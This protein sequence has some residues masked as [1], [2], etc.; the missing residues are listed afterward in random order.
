MG[1][2]VFATRR[3][4][5]LSKDME[6]GVFV[7]AGISYV[8]RP[9]IIQRSVLNRRW[10]MSELDARFVRTS[11]FLWIVGAGGVVLLWVGIRRLIMLGV[12]RA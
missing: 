3:E 2:A 8:V 1:Y 9:S 5:H 6:F 4:Q 11:W 7:A 12:F 10:R